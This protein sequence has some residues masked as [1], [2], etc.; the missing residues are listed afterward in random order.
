MK[1]AP[2]FALAVVFA[3]AALPALAGTSD[4]KACNLV[5]FA[6]AA[7][8]LGTPVDKLTTRS[9]GPET[10]CSYHAASAFKR[11][12]FSTHPT[13]SVAAAKELF[14]ETITSTL[15]QM[16][17]SVNVPGIGDEAHRLG[18]MIFVRRGDT[19][20][21]FSQLAADTNGSG[22]QRTISV[23]RTVIARLH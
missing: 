14:H 6:D 3:A 9:T 19:V 8:A 2:A 1:Y 18:P 23:A 5:T 13:S 10:T 11:F 15:T 21:A 7:E 20:Y 12:E 17:P 4:P 22:A 16:S